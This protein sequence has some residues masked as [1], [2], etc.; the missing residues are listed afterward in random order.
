MMQN[1]QAVCANG[2]WGHPT[3]DLSP[4]CVEGNY[5]EAAPPCS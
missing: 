5:E 4:E 1:V 3:N 2:M